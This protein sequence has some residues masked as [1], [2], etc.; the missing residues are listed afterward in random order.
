[1]RREVV[2]AILAKSKEELLEKINAV[3]PFVSAVHVDVMDGAFVDNQ[4][5]GP[6]E[7]AVLPP[8]PEYRFHLMV[9]H[10][11]TYILR[12][13][14]PSIYV[15]H[16]EAKGSIEAAK[17][18]AEKCGGKLGLALNPDTPLELIKPYF[19]I[20]DYYLLMTVNPGYS[21]QGYISGVES[22]IE[23]LRKIVPNA[24]IAVDGGIGLKT[25]GGARDAGANIFCAASAIFGKEDRKK[26]IDELTGAANG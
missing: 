24:D 15:I 5:V 18:A 13:A 22:K 11:E 3:S 12:I 23:K 16:V 17:L 14:K 21:G 25:L 19:D 8:G 20:I 10:P 1:M 26:A 7:L 6:E 4:T 2:P 9:M